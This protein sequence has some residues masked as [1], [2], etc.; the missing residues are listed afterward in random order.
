M[1]SYFKNEQGEPIALPIGKAICVGRNYEEHIKELNSLATGRP[2]LFM[3]PSSAFSDVEKP[4]AIPA[5]MGECHNELEIALLIGG[6]VDKHIPF[7]PKKHVVGVG[8]ALDLTL[9]DVQN[10]CKEKGHPWEIAKAFDGSCPLSKFV[11]IGPSEYQNLHFQL[12]VNGELRQSGNS[13]H[14]I[15]DIPA[16]ID[17]IRQYFTLQPGDVVL[18]G[19]PKGVGP[20]QEGDVL[21]LSLSEHTKQEHIKVSTQ[22]VTWQ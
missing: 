18:T 10:A 22:V 16:L 4:I 6:K 13:A 2:L 7:N 9:R 1:I 5:G 12:S 8:L 19:T 14:M 15:F 3:K 11:Q 21:S 20:L 17:E